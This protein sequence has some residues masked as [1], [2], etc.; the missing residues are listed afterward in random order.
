M[1][2]RRIRSALIIPLSEDDIA[3]PAVPHGNGQRISIY[4][5]VAR[6]RSLPVRFEGASRWGRPER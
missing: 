5:R 4:P 2:A 6:A 1:N 3:A